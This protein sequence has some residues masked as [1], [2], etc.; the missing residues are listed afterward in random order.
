MFANEVH[1]V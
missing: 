1:P